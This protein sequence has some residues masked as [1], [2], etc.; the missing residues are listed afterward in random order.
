MNIAKINKK[1]R[2]ASQRSI[3]LLKSKC[4]CSLLPELWKP[5]LIQVSG[6]IQSTV[7]NW[8]WPSVPVLLADLCL[9]LQRHWRGQSWP[10]GG[11][12]SRS[13]TIPDNESSTDACHLKIRILGIPKIWMLLYSMKRMPT[14]KE[15]TVRKYCPGFV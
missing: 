10:S 14:I 1:E 11:S 3:I 2:C 12:H 6:L 4:L 7:L 5:L 13:S 9:R 8:L 15:F